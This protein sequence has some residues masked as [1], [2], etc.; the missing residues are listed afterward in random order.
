MRSEIFHAWISIQFAPGTDGDPPDEVT[1][2]KFV[3]YGDPPDEV[4]KSKVS[5]FGDS[6]KV[7]KYGDSGRKAHKL[8]CIPHPSDPLRL[9]I[10]KVPKHKTMRVGGKWVPV[11]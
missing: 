2:S 11:V 9:T 6:G 4:T 7:S 10:R 1:T 5:K 8:V 3:K